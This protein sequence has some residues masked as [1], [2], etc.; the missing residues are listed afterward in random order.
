[1]R[2][3]VSCGHKLVYK[4]KDACTLVSVDMPSGSTEFLGYLCTVQIPPASQHDRLSEKFRLH[5]M[6]KED[7][8]SFSSGVFDAVL[9]LEGKGSFSIDSLLFPALNI[10]GI[11]TEE[12]NVLINNVIVPRVLVEARK[13]KECVTAV[14]IKANQTLHISV[15]PS[16]LYVN[17]VREAVGEK[18]VASFVCRLPWTSLFE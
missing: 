7:K 10:R 17:G 11:V 9:Q 6:S 18:H 16:H 13:R 5:D 15:K 14:Y 4:P 8:K 3:L 2:S 12:G 1:M